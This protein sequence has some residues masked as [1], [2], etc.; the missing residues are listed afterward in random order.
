MKKLKFGSAGWE[1]AR[2]TELLDALFA[3]QERLGW[4][5]QELAD[6]LEGGGFFYPKRTL[7]NWR[8]KDNLPR[9][10]MFFGLSESLKFLAK[11]GPRVKAA[12]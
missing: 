3:E 9:R 10:G 11:K 5:C 6:A 7:D 12:A 8:I 1:K 2:A 4:T